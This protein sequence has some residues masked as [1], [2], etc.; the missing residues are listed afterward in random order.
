MIAKVVSENLISVLHLKCFQK[1]GL[2]E[3]SVYSMDIRV[4]WVGVE[5]R[6]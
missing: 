3:C 5:S 4:G 6:P 2:G 1:L